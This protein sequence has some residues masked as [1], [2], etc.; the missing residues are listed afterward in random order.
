[1]NPLFYAVL[2]LVVA[3]AS[4]LSVENWYHIPWRMPLLPQ[5][6]NSTTF[7][8]SRKQNSRS[9]YGKNHSDVSPDAAAPVHVVFSSTMDSVAGVEAAIRSVQEH[10]KGPVEFYFIGKDPLPVHSS[11]NQQ[12]SVHWFNLTKVA[13]EYKLAEY[14]NVGFEGRDDNINVMYANYARFALADLFERY[15]PSATKI[16]YLDNDV[17]VLCDVHSLVRNALLDDRKNY[18]VAAVPRYG[19]VGHK[20]PIRGLVKDSEKKLKKEF[21]KVSKSFNAGVYI[22]HLQRWRNQN[23]SEQIRALAL[24]NREEYLYRG[25]SQPPFNLIIGDEFEDLPN[26]WNSGASGYERFLNGESTEQVCIVHYKG[27][28]H[29]WENKRDFGGKD[30]WLRYGTQIDR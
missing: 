27:G 25:G 24:R 16:L 4:L 9:D 15:V 7:S 22:V 6:K 8:W 14:M 30:L 29:P 28:I 26:G 3:L 13:S 12:V 2:L 18:A 23:I 5:S 11:S 1:M 20:N 17:L 21:G 19:T 10:A